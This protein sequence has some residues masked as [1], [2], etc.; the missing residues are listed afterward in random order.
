MK[1]KV[2]VTG[3]ARGIGKAIVEELAKNGYE[4]IATYNSTKP[5]NLANVIYYQVNLRDK[6]EINKFLKKITAE[7]AIDILVNNAG[8]WC[9]KLFE[10][11]SEDEL[12]EQVEL[13]FAAPARLIKGLL[14]TLK[15]SK[16]PLIINISSQAAHPLYAGEAMYSASKSA[17]STLSQVLRT[18]LNPGGVRVVTVEPW[19][20]DTYGTKE[21]ND[22]LLSS[23]VAELVLYITEAPAHIQFETVGIG[24]IKQWRGEYPKWI[25][26]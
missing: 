5:A 8:I 2:L 23:E 24:H 19:R 4:V 18:E 7:P 11:M 20:V 12:F 21:P 16:A 1:K 15:E 17:I 14:P 3:G 6:K 9:G 10:Q 25:K 26:K 22:K 13:N